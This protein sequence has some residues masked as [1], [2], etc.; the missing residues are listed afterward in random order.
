M[1]TPLLLPDAA[2]RATYDA[3]FA[4]GSAALRAGQAT[5]DAYLRAAPH[6]DT[7]RGLTVLAAVRGPAA[8]AIA[9]EQAALR[10][11]EPDLY[12]YPS[13]DLHVTVISLLT[14]RSGR[15]PD[16]A[17]S[18]AY[19]AL[20]RELLA[21]APPLRLRFEGFTLTAEAILAQGY[22][23]VA[24]QPLREAIR[25]GAGAHGLPL[26][27]RYHSPTAHATIG[28][29]AQVPRQPAALAGWVAARRELPL[30]EEVITELH[31]VAHDWYNRQGRSQLLA[32]LPLLGGAT[33]V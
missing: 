3:L 14:A 28:R 22:P 1:P 32:R 12:Y 2:L 18:G 7:R 13:A 26:D 4:A 9:R 21:G 19:E 33:P 8:T 5:P 16:P 11:A 6:L 24:F 27:E 29:F 15:E 23:D 31:L 10:A 17:V 30:G 20:L 25:R